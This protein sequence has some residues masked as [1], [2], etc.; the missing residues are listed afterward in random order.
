[1]VKKAPQTNTEPTKA[2]RIAAQA[3]EMMLSEGMRKLSTRVFAEL[4]DDEIF[5]EQRRIRDRHIGSVAA[6]LVSSNKKNISG[7]I[8]D[9][10]RQIVES[11]LDGEGMGAFSE[12]FFDGIRPHGRPAEATPADGDISHLPDGDF[13]VV[14]TNTIV[15]RL[16][17]EEPD[18]IVFLEDALS[19]IKQRRQQGGKTFEGPENYAT[20]IKYF[21]DKTYDRPL[22]ETQK[23]KRTT[24]A[25]VSEALTGF[26]R[27]SQRDDANIVEVTN[28]L[29]A[30]KTL[31]KGSVEPRFTPN[32]LKHTVHNLDQFT[33]RG[34]T[35]LIGALGKLDVSECPEE[36]AMTL[37]LAL[38]KG[39][40]MDKTSDMLSVLRALTNLP[41]S[42]ASERAVSTFL[43][44]RNQLEMASNLDELEEINKSLLKIVEGVTESR[45]DSQAIKGIS[46]VAA[47]EAMKQ[48][49]QTTGTPMTLEEMN[50]RKNQVSRIITT[51]KRI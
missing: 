20:T 51:A 36:A 26:D 50:A 32:I 37:D 3:A 15:K 5:V 31:P 42:R 49:A 22:G 1:M 7:R 47:R 24:T 39:A 23:E 28:I 27:T 4:N 9:A 43:L 18:P 21:A 46:S 16:S 35:V 14:Q 12:A 10:Q 30:I 13:N 44:V 40:G 25:L 17:Q 48:L 11:S 6:T 2:D 19:A 34:I 45:I 41:H 29:S 38:R 8:W 33:E